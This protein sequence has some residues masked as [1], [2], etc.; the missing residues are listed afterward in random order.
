MSQSVT[1][2][3]SLGLV[4]G[5]IGGS[6]RGR[7][8]APRGGGKLLAP[9]FPLWLPAHLPLTSL[10]PCPLASLR[11]RFSTSYQTGHACFNSLSSNCRGW[12][13]AG[14]EMR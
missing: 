1:M 13:G 12:E 7:G 6:P 3:L 5:G 9:S 4:V 10:F 14:G 2:G 11:I 8:S